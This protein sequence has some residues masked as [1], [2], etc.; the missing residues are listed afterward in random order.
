MSWCQA[1]RFLL[2]MSY[3]W[4]DLCICVT[5]LM[6]LCHAPHVCAWHVFLMCVPWLIHGW[7]PGISIPASHV[8]YWTWKIHPCHAPH[9]CIWRDPLMCVPWIILNICAMTHSWVDA[10]PFHSCLTGRTC[11]L[12]QLFVWRD[13]CAHVTWLNEYGTNWVS[14]T[15][16]SKWI[17][18]KPLIT[19]EKPDMGWLW[20]VGSIKW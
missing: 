7:M 3:V 9:A 16:P 5:W 19:S 8:I 1:F 18:K 4:R 11:D 20:S 12:T 13:S 10:R 6:Y 15:T 17:P 14:Y 2:H